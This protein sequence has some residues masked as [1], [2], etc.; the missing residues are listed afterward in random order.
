MIIDR[1][2]F[3]GNNYPDGVRFPSSNLGAYYLR[4]RTRSFLTLISLSQLEKTRDIAIA[5]WSPATSCL[6]EFFSS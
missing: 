6:L 4:T 1:G 3:N 2:V 5:V